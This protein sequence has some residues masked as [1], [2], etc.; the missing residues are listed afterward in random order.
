[1]DH[2]LNRY[3]D[4]Y[5]VV[6]SST[7]GVCSLIFG[8]SVFL[9]SRKFGIVR[10]DSVAVFSYSW[11]LITAMILCSLTFFLNFLIEGVIANF[12]SDMYQQ[13]YEESCAGLS[14]TDYFQK[15]M[16]EK[17]LRYLAPGSLLSCFFSLCFM[18]GWCVIHVK[19]SGHCV[20]RRLYHVKKRD[21]ND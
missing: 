2:Y 13:K 8:A 18:I 6:I 5:E 4:S 19:K 16:R 15:N 7:N 12:F 21:H 20:K 3:I 10:D 17:R 11:M 1:M 14:P 9:M